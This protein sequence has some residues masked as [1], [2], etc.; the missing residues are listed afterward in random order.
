[1]PL[2]GYKGSGLGMM[3]EILCGVLSGGAMSTEV[4]GVYIL[5]RPIWELATSSLRLTSRG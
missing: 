2:G 3:V 5:T 4:G 1:M